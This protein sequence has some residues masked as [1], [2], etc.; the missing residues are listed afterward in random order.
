MPSNHISN[1][2]YHQNLTC[3][4]DWEHLYKEK[5]IDLVKLRHRCSQHRQ[6]IEFAL[7]YLIEM[8]D[9]GHE[10]VNITHLTERSVW[11]KIKNK[12]RESG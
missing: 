11:D 10:S 3:P 6:A 7:E 1:F 2:D 4:V 8:G 5:A 9:V 12:R